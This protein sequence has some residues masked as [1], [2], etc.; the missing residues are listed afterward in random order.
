MIFYR[1]ITLLKTYNLYLAWLISVIA[2]LGSLYFSEIMQFEPCKLCWFQRICMYPLSI[3]LGMGAFRNDYDIIPYTRVLS[4]IG[5]F[6]AIIH[7]LEQ[8]V[9][10]MK[11]VVL[12]TIGVPCSGY[13]INW[14]GFITIPF[15]ALISFFLINILLFIRREVD[16]E[17]ISNN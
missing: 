2:V 14:F 17:Y 9:P 11:N 4:F 7:Y 12:C 8:K 16:E 6:I 1:T 10:V 5:M 13:Y 15:L 3:L